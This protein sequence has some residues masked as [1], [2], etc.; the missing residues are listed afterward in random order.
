[1]LSAVVGLQVIAR[2]S[3]TPYKKTSKAPQQIAQELGAQYLLTATVRWEK[4]PGGASTVHVSPELV[5]VR[6]GSAPTTKWQQSFD[7][8]LTNVFQ[9]QADIA[10]R[11]A[12]SLDV[13]L[14]STAQRQLAARPTTNL[15][16]YDAFL[17]GEAMF[18]NMAGNPLHPRR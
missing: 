1:M 17:R 5:Q 13:A 9:V 11:V 8:Q 14:G 16:A 3:S 18:E 15:A 12:Q 4:L 6:S 7:A 10:T 2:G